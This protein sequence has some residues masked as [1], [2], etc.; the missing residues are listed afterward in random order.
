MGRA[1]PCLIASF[2]VAAFI[3]FHCNLPAR[4]LTR[5]FQHTAREGGSVSDRWRGVHFKALLTL[6][7][8]DAV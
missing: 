5:C 3:I 2:I 1:S 7:E 4:W 6:Q 8:L